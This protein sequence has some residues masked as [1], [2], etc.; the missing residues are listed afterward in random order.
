MTNDGKFNDKYSM[1]QMLGQGAFGEVR[2]CQNRQTK[3]VRAVK[4]IRKESM[5][6]E[7]EKSFRYEIN[8]LKKLDHPNIIKLYEIFED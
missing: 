5:T 4:I 8:I 6:P 1:G 7:E 2:K 3:T